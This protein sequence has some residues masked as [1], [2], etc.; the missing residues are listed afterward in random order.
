M[1]DPDLEEG[2]HFHFLN[3]IHDAP[4]RAVEYH[5]LIVYATTGVRQAP[6]LHGRQGRCRRKTRHCRSTAMWGTRGLSLELRIGTFDAVFYYE[7]AICVIQRRGETKSAQNLRSTKF[8][9]STSETTTS[10]A[11][12][13]ETQLRSETAT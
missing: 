5:C 13:A 1:P 10:E 11:T 8:K 3:A 7:K 6:E 12:T 2:G 9:N 4:G